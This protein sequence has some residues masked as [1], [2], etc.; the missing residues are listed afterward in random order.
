M[1]TQVRLVDGARE[2][3][4]R[5]RDGIAAAKL[6]WG[7]PEVRAVVENATD[8]DGTND[9]TQHHGA[10]AVSLELTL[11]QP[12]TTRALIDELRSYCHPGRRPYLYVTDDEWATERRIQ[13]RAD[14]QSA[15]ITAG[16]GLNRGVQIAWRAPAGVWEDVDQGVTT[17]PANIPDGLGLAVPVVMPATFTN[18]AGAS[19]RTVTNAG[20]TP[21]YW[22]ARMYGPC[23]G[24]QLLNVDTGETLLFKPSLA[25]GAGEYIEV[26]VRARSVFFLGDRSDSRLGQVDYTA[27]TW[28]RFPADTTTTVRYFADSAALGA[29]C[30][31][32]TRT[33]W[34]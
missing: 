2:M 29:Q 34:L 30:E 22:V 28:W 14:Q 4:L 32:Y 17:V 3:I 27:T 25:L 1:L 6:D 19:V 16:N 12:G 23:T 26:D 10:S 33:Q 18:T 11:Y 24:P 13:L 20:T 21:L 15:P 9:T 8:T 5:P 7:F 31:I